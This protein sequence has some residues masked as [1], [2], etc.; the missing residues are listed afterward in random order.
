MQE[1]FNY[2]QPEYNDLFWFSLPRTSVEVNQTLPE[3]N[4]S[5]MMGGNMAFQH[6]PHIQESMA[7]N[8]PD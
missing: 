6:I 1:I 3:T 2:I 5:P 4:S 7:G 8:Y